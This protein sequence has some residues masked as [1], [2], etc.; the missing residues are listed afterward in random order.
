METELYYQMI[1]ATS[2]LMAFKDKVATLDGNRS[3]DLSFT[4]YFVPQFYFKPIKTDYIIA[5]EEC[6]L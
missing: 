1:C 6:L 4:A 5:I 2:S 3:I